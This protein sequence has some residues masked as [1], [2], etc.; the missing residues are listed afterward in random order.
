MQRTRRTFLTGISCLSASALAGQAA[1]QPA[2]EARVPT[3]PQR[4]A[5]LPAWRYGDSSVAD[6][7]LLMFR[8]NGPHTFYGTG[9]IPEKAPEIVWR[10]RTASYS[11]VNHGVPTLW[12]GT[13]WTGTAVKLG[14][15]VYVGSVG[16]YVYAFEAMTGELIW[17]L[18]SG[19]MFK[20]SCCA[21]ENRLYIGNT[22]NL[23]RC[24]D[25]QTGRIVWTYD[26][27]NDLDSSPC[28][29]AGK[30]YVA[31]ENGFVRCLDPRSGQLLWKTFV[32]GIGEGTLLG[33]NGSETS[34]AIADGELYGATYDGE[35][36]KIDIN[37]GEKRWVANVG[38]DTDASVTIAGDFIYTAA[39]EKAS[40]LCCLARADGKEVWRYAGNALGYWSTPAVAEGRVHIGGEDTTLHT[41]DARSGAVLWTF[42][43]GDG[44]WSSPSV[45]G[46]RVIFGS[47]DFN[48][49]CLDAASG[50]EVWRV[51]LDGRIISSPC[52]VG[53]KIWIGT[54]TGYFYC[55]SA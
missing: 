41:L 1:A 15:Y 22:D 29:I 7:T 38:D 4:V 47:R 28:V 24:I 45:V 17:Q 51:K 46:G 44:I 18:A 34:P 5:R 53:G 43:T 2:A 10:F 21:F 39:E 50:T 20:G 32:G 27:G 11:T 3:A 35:L 13:G 19:G 42:K 40:Y 25:A 8:G 6:D 23:L 9:P 26:T 36:Y 31:G 52:I 49:Y 12:S 48:L 14:D 30:L 37:S 16:G 54:A 33:S 55:L